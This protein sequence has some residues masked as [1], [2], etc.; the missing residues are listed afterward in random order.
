[1][2]LNAVLEA[3]TPAEVATRL[4]ISQATV[5]RRIK[6]GEIHAVKVGNRHR[7]PIME[8]HRFRR[9]LMQSMVDHYANDIEDDLLG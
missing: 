3:L 1:M 9:S 5:L 4:G 8:Y 6:S 2:Q 7:I